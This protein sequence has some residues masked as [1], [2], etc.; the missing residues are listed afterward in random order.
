LYYSETERIYCVIMRAGTSKGIFLHVNDLPQD[1][2]L[3]DKVI[4][5]IFGSPDPR[6]I[7]GLGGAEP[8]T[9]KLALIGPSSRP[10]ADVDY[11]FGQVEINQPVIHYSGLDG[12]ISAGVGPYAIE[13]GLVKA[14]EPITTV[15]VHNTNTK[16]IIIADVPVYN[17]KPKAMGDYAIDGVPG[18]GCRI[19]IDMSQTAGSKTGKLLPTGN[20]RDKIIVEGAGEINIS[21]VDVANPCIFVQAQEVGLIGN[22]T[23]GEFNNNLSAINILER[24]RAIGAEMIGINT[25][26]KV[27]AKDP[28]PFIAFVS[29]RRQA[30]NHLTLEDIPAECVSFLSRLLFLGAMHQTYAGSV[31]VATGVA[32]VIPGTVVNEVAKLEKEQKMI[33]IGHPGGI[34]EVEAEV[35]TINNQQFNLLR[36]M[37][38][39]TARRLMD[40]YV[41]ISRDTFE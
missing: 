4:L 18:T 21:I 33:R 8:L 16:Q 27:S 12:N 39:R 28:V 11:T 34:V 15:K 22:E 41:Y 1:R 40:G 32:A 26:G 14:V 6:Q 31:S 36:A 24:I 17:G 25:P 35:E 10:D 9:S 3:R 13:E 7:D 30:I 37:Y 23:P 29:T 2:A 19:N 5:S 20:V 38:S